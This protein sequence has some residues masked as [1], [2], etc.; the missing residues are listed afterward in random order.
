MGMKNSFVKFLILTQLMALALTGCKGSSESHSQP[1]NPFG[2]PVSLELPNWWTREPVVFAGQEKDA[3]VNF[4]EISVPQ[5]VMMAIA[6]QPISVE[7]FRHVGQT[8]AGAF[9]NGIIGQEIPI[10]YGGTDLS[11]TLQLGFSKPVPVGMVALWRSNSYGSDG[12]KGTIEVDPSALTADRFLLEAYFA[13]EVAAHGSQ[14][15]SLLSYLHGLTGSDYSQWMEL[16]ANP[17]W[18][19]NGFVQEVTA[20]AMTYDYLTTSCTGC[21]WVD[22]LGVVF[23]DQISHTPFVDWSDSDWGTWANVV[24]YVYLQGTVPVGQSQK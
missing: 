10:D 4:G 9:E 15:Y 17:W 19:A 5:D 2:T 14:H 6:L 24:N 1:T 11:V 8:L 3:P 21:A 12:Y 23:Q 18:N 13:H 16:I 22:P 20:N 7:Y